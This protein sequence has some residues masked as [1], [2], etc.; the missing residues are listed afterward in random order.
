LKTVRLKGN[1]LGHA[2]HFTLQP[3]FEKL[4]PLINIWQVMLEMREEMHVGLQVKHPLLLSSFNQTWNNWNV[5][6]NFSKTP[7]MKFHKKSFSGF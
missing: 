4:F 7:S 6:P 3:L 2:L 1:A 5:F